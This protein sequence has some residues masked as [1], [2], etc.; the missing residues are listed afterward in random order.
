MPYAQRYPC[1]SLT[2]PDTDSAHPECTAT[3]QR[4]TLRS[5][6]TANE[7]CQGWLGSRL[8]HRGPGFY[9]CA[10]AF[11]RGRQRLFGCIRW[12]DRG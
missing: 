5:L 3:S 10:L 6:Q 1:D 11:H 8:E 9:A 12:F 7:T 4:I 2:Y